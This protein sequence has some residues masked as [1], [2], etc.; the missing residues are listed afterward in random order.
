MISGTHAIVVGYH[1]CD[2]SLGKRIL[3]GDVG[4]KPSR[5][6]YDWLGHGAYFWENNY[7]RAWLWAEQLKSRS[8]ILA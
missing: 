7:E 1:G 6:K 5:N 4:L 2:K 8:F 3:A